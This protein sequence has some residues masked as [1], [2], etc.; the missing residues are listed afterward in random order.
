MITP[1][2][3]L[4][5]LYYFV[6]DSV[7]YD[8]KQTNDDDNCGIYVVE[9]KTEEK[10]VKKGDIYLDHNHNKVTAEEDATVQ[11]GT[12]ELND[13]LD[14]TIF[15]SFFVTYTEKTEGAEPKT[16]YYWLQDMI[17]DGDKYSGGK[18]TINTAHGESY[19]KVFEDSIKADIDRYVEKGYTYETIKSV[20]PYYV[21][22]EDGDE[23]NINGQTVV[24]NSVTGL[25][26]DIDEEYVQ[27]RIY[28]IINEKTVKYANGLLKEHGKKLAEEMPDWVNSTTVIDN[29]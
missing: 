7:V 13:V 3:T 14:Y 2:S 12:N 20:M 10:E 8:I 6:N 9:Y 22:A 27:E 19:M 28:A 1:K 23:V 5:D 26:L 24:F 29:E 25:D 11:A 4:K 16:K 21:F 15:P 18:F 17:K